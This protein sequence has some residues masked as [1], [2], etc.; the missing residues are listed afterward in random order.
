[1]DMAFEQG[2]QAGQWSTNLTGKTIDLQGVAAFASLV[3]LLAQE[4]G[5]SPG[6]IQ[7][8]LPSG[9]ASFEELVGEIVLNSQGFQRTVLLF[10]KPGAGL[11]MRI[12]CLWRDN[13]MAD[14]REKEMSGGVDAQFILDAPVESI[15]PQGRALARH[16]EEAFAVLDRMATLGQSSKIASMSIST[17]ELEKFES[18]ESGNLVRNSRPETSQL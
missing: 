10:S 12:K 4:L 18:A 6:R 11:R 3:E 16:L 15:L 17:A 5:T 9:P 2:H 7:G 13:Y 1:M 14:Y 8:L